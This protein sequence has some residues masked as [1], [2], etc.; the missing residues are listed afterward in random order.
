MTSFTAIA[1]WVAFAPGERAFSS[2]VSGGGVAVSG[3]GGEWV[4][5]IAFGFGA[6]LCAVFA[7]F[8]WKRVLF[9]PDRSDGPQPP[10]G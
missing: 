9:P 7:A 8:L 6:I 2:S 4:G 10:A 1:G 3:G 5:R